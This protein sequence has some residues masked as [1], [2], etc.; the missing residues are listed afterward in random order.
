MCV[1]VDCR[2]CEHLT[3]NRTVLYSYCS[4][5]STTTNRTNAEFHRAL[6]I[7]DTASFTRIRNRA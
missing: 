5:N 2:F 7:T 4:F 1:V 3:M 6:I